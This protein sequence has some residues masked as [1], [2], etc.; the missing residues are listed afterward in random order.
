[1][2]TVDVKFIVNFEYCDE[3]TKSTAIKVRV[4][5]IL[6]SLQLNQKTPNK[7]LVNV[8]MFIQSY[9]KYESS[10]KKSD[11]VTRGV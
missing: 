3:R 7:S 9:Y 6:Y 1:M 2:K 11:L 5:T 10:H 8:R 4:R